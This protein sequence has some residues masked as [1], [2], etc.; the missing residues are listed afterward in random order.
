[1]RRL[2][3]AAARLVQDRLLLEEDAER[4]VDAASATDIGKPRR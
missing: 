3:R 2:A 1:V 4:I